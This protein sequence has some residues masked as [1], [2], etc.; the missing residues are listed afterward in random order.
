MPEK[1]MVPLYDVMNNFL[2]SH[3][4]SRL[5]GSFGTNSP[6]YKEARAEWEAL[7]PEQA[8]RNIAELARLRREQSREKRAEGDIHMNEIKV[9]ENQ[10]FGSLEV[11]MIDGKEH[12]P[13]TDCAKMLGYANPRK[14]IIDHCKGVT[15]RDSPT[16][17]GVQEKNYITLGD[18]SRLIANSQLPAAQKFES[19]VFDD[20]VPS[21]LRT[22][23]Y[24][25]P[26][27]DIKKQ[28][29]EAMLMNAKTRTANMWYK[30]GGLLPE[31]PQH[32]QICASYASEALTGRKVI[33]LPAVEQTYSA[34]E[35]GKL[36]GVTGNRVGR[37]ANKHGL[38]ADEYGV[39]VMDKAKYSAKEVPS[40][41][42]NERGAAAIGRH[43]QDNHA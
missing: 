18:L 32:K 13:A 21:V 28:R 35:V 17:S 8:Q 31:S 2:N 6:Q 29:A 15:K 23:A 11:V 30:L 10:Q 37:I 36:Y 43:L 41:R 24:T 16:S 14:A 25:A 3:E 7:H 20:I 40:F 1:V 38:K 5:A 9:F 22:G 39:T 19:W 42:Y 26:G 27:V 33:A 12:F 4:G 34:E